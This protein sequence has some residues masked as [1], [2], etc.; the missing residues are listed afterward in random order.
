[1][2][3]RVSNGCCATCGEVERRAGSHCDRYVLPFSV[4]I[5]VW[6]GEH[7]GIAAVTFLQNGL[8]VITTQRA[9]RLRFN[10]VRNVSVPD[11]KT[12]RRCV[13]A[14]EETGSTAMP[15]R[16]GRPRTA[17]TLENVALV[18]AVVEQSPRH[19]VRRHAIALGLSNRKEDFA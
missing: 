5:M 6:T 8:S 16:I 12:I 1:M 3:A 17:S 13:H 11:G 9:M 4:R 2:Y 7:R 15:H 19:S 14:F 10:I 18:R